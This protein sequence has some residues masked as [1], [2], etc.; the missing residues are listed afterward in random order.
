MRFSVFLPPAAAPAP[1][2]PPLYY[3]AGLEC[4][5]Q[6]FVDQGGRPARRRGAGPG[7]RHLR[8]QPARRA[9]SRATTRAGTSARA[10]ASTSTPRRSPGGSRYR[11]DSYV[12]ARAARAGRAA[13]PG[14]AATCAASSGTRWAATARSRWRCATRIAIAASPRSRPSSRRRRCPGARRRS[15][16]YLGDDRDAWSATT[17]AISC[18]RGRCPARVLI[19][20]GT[21]DKFLE[22]ELKPGAVRGGVRRRRARRWSSGAHAA[23]TT[24]TTSSRRSSPIT[25]APRARADGVDRRLRP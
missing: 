20:V 1:R 25:C 21:A 22:R 4:T 18:A 2:A 23:T 24:A 5:E 8:H 11:M 12:T 6:T 9:L 16:G 14:R 3:L 19:D 15:R 10:P 17:R 7:A 13:L